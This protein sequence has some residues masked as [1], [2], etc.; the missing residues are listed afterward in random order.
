MNN[1]LTRFAGIWFGIAVLVNM[2]VIAGALI[3]SAGVWDGIGQVRDAYDPF[4]IRT[5]LF[6]IGLFAP[7]IIAIFWRNLRAN[8]PT[9]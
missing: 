1:S 3:G 9:D 6:Q 4:D 7:M 5:W 2:L 8:R